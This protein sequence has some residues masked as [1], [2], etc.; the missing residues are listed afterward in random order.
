MKDDILIIGD[1]HRNA[2]KSLLEHILPVSERTVM[3]IAGESGA[4]K[5][6]IAA[7]LAGEFD[8]QGYRAFIFQQDDYFILPP[9]TNE[10]NRR[11]DIHRVGMQE[12]RLDLL[13]RHLS[14]AK[15]GHSSL[16][17]PL[18]SFRD[19]SIGSETIDLAGITVFIAEGTYTSVLRSTD[20][21]VFIDRDLHDTLEA[22][23]QRNREQQD[24]FLE[25][26]LSIEHEII[27]KHKSLADYIITMNWEVIQVTRQT[28]KLT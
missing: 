27:S 14:E 15:A 10:R 8:L 19:D 11:E 7:A 24:E 13:D 12:V 28:G 3:T 2:A 17:K 26:V 22:R 16:N 21:R 23:R 5:S 9:H 1:H 25:R 6:E 4:G 18:V 20:I